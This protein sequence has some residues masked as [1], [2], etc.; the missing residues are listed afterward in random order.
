MTLVNVS[1]RSATL[2]QLH[3]LLSIFLLK[4]FR[5]QIYSVC[6]NFSLVK[7]VILLPNMAFCSNQV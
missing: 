4:L 1:K 5:G 7:F 2:I 3:W 6:V